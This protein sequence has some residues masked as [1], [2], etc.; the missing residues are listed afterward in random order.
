MHGHLNVKIVLD[1]YQTISRCVGLTNLPPSCAD[2]LDIWEPQPLYQTVKYSHLWKKQDR[3][4]KY[5][6]TLKFVRAT[7]VAVEKQ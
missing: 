5:N 7:I 6:V 1:L 4:C 2:C 3:K